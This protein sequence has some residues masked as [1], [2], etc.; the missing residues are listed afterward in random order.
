MFIGV[1]AQLR[2]HAPEYARVLPQTEPPSKLQKMKSPHQTQSEGYETLTQ[3]SSN[4]SEVK[5]V[6]DFISYVISY[7]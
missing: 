4:A 5:F 1:D 2:I 7:R 6:I 3:Y